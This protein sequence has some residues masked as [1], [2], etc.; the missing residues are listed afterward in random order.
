MTGAT[1]PTPPLPWDRR[2]DKGDC[3]NAYRGNSRE[4]RLQGAAVDGDVGRRARA[5]GRP[6]RRADLHRGRELRRR[7]RHH[8]RCGGRGRGDAGHG[9]G[10]GEGRPAGRS[11]RRPGGPQDGDGVPAGAAVQSGRRRPRRPE[12][13]GRQRLR[14][15][16]GGV[17]EEDRVSDRHGRA[18]RRGVHHLY[19]VHAPG[20]RRRERGLQGDGQPERRHDRRPRRAGPDRR[21]RDPA[22]DFAQTSLGVVSPM[23]PSRTASRRRACPSSTARSRSCRRRRA[24]PTS[25]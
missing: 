17:R 11:R 7:R 2:I 5:G 23:R 6:G 9:D 16:R 15:P 4:R 20:P 8:R 21:R 19:R 13:G 1:S 24:R 12:S 18:V 25:R 22:S 3:A 14:L 10:A